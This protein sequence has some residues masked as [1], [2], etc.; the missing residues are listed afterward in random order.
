MEAPFYF[1]FVLEV[2][3][4]AFVC[5]SEGGEIVDGV[6]GEEVENCVMY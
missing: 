1:A 5:S 2:M 3:C 4:G 6:N